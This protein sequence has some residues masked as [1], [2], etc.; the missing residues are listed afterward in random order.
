MMPKSWIPSQEPLP[1]KIK[2]TAKIQPLIEGQHLKRMV[3]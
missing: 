3:R 1:G 2:V